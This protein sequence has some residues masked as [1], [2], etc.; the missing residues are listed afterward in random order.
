MKL[1][2]IGVM[3]MMIMPTIHDC[4]WLYFYHNLELHSSGMD[5]DTNS[6]PSHSLGSRM[7]I[8]SVRLHEPY[9]TTG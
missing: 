7:T 9:G 8:A 1:C 3:I 4:Q 2:Y 5:Y 6:I